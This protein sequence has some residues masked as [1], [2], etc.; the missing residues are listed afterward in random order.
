MKK[1]NI[2]NKVAGTGIILYRIKPCFLEQ[3]VKK[4]ISI[5]KNFNF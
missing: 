4:F 2:F 3:G 1:W 5:F